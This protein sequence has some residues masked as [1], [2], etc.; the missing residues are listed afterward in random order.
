MGISDL[1]DDES[2]TLHSL[3]I[4]DPKTRDVQRR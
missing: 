1:G 3:L 4:L 2:D